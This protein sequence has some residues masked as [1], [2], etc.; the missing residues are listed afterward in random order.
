MTRAITRQ[1]AFNFCRGP[2]I[3]HG[4]NVTCN[5]DID[6]FLRPNENSACHPVGTCMMGKDGLSAVD[7]ELHV[8]GFEGL[9]V[10]DASIMPT[11]TKGNINASCIMIGERASTFILGP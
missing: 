1:P 5:K 10:A 9:R 4:P 8:Y 6:A 11:V 3:F 7:P 2:E